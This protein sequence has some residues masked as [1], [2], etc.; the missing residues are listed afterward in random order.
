MTGQLLVI[1][2]NDG[3]SSAQDPGQ[4]RCRVV[5]P[6]GWETEFI[7]EKRAATGQGVREMTI[8]KSRASPGLTPSCRRRMKGQCVSSFFT[9]MTG[10]AGSGK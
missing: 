4:S 5:M 3:S 2:A 1:R 6:A 9:I 7:E 10:P 8:G